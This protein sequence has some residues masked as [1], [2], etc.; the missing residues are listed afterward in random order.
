MGGMW[1]V[2]M[3]KKKGP[4]PPNLATEQRPAL[5]PSFPMPSFL[6]LPLLF[7]RTRRLPQPCPVPCN[8]RHHRA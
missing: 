3:T 4:P 8:L 7:P 5:K 6:I 1:L 2:K